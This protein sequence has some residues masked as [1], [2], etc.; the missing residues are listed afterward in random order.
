MGDDID[1]R[2]EFSIPSVPPAYLRSA[3][4]FQEMIVKLDPE[5]QIRVGAM[6]TDNSMR[7]WLT[8]VGNAAAARMVTTMTYAEVADRTGRSV[9][10]INQRVRRHRD[11]TRD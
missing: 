1:M 7:G 8:T 10:A 2:N 9:S 4:A 6:L 11:A 3:E 5:W